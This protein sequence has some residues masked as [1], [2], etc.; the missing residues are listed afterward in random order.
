MP[1]YSIVLY[2]HVVEFFDDV[3]S[4][5]NFTPSCR[6]SFTADSSLPTI[7]AYFCHGTCAGREV[8]VVMYTY[9]CACMEVPVPT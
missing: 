3:M 8:L 2:S 4:N 1:F 9:A 6:L 5:R 7:N